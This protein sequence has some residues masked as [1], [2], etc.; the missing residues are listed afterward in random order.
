MQGDFLFEKK[1]KKIIKTR[2]VH[3][4]AHILYLMAQQ[5]ENHHDWTLGSVCW[6]PHSLV[7]RARRKGLLPLSRRASLSLLTRRQTGEASAAQELPP[8]L[9]PRLMPHLR[10]RSPA[11]ACKRRA[12]AAPRDPAT[13][14]AGATGRTQRRRPLEPPTCR[15]AACA[16]CPANTPEWT[17]FCTRVRCVRCFVWPSRVHSTKL[18]QTLP[19]APARKRVPPAG[20][21]QPSSILPGELVFARGELVFASASNSFKFQKASLAPR[22]LFKF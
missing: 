15:S 2:F 22:R 3:A 9:Q 5:A 6:D 7:R 14:D 10:S 19:H 17:A 16:R 11:T 8:P 18:C 12:A 1:I 21:G 13:D 20:R 4:T